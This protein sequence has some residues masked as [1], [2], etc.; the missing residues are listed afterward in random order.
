MWAVH[1]GLS[2]DGITSGSCKFGVPFDTCVEWCCTFHG[3]V[4]LEEGVVVPSHGVGSAARYTGGHRERWCSRVADPGARGADRSV[5]VDRIKDRVAEHSVDVPVPQ[6]R[7]ETAEVIQPVP[8]ERI[9]DRIA[10]PIVDIP[11]PPCRRW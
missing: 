10:D 7:R 9:K 4:E 3:V 11:V 6:T 5:P 8:V 2:Q 1:G